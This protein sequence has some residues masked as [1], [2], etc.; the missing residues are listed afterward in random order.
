MKVL[1]AA[2]AGTFHNGGRI[3]FGPDRHLYV[4]I[5]D[6]AH[7]A[8]AQ[9][10][11]DNK[12]G[13]VLRMTPS[14]TVPADNPFGNYVWA[15]G[16]RNSF[17]LGFDP[18]T[19]RLWQTENGP[20]CNDEL[21]RIDKGHNFGWGPSWTCSTPPPPPKNTNQDGPSPVKPQRWYTP[22][23]APTGI[24][25]CRTCGLGAESEGDL[26]FGAWKTGHIRRVN[27]GQ[28]RSQVA[29]EEVVYD[30]PDGILSVERAR[31]G[32]LYFS[33]RSGIYRLALQ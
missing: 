30:H 12:V 13:K 1:F 3:L 17:G 5:G 26:F 10:L 23:I 2:V 4:V 9:D 24:A 15:Y 27:L 21:N 20:E 7:P 33:D 19:G 16:I 22:P 11:T 18:F 32:A 6:R 28:Q 8:N 29:A 25:F 14:G 31:T